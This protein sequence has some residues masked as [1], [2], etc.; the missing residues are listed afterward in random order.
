MSRVEIVKDGKWALYCFLIDAADRPGH[1]GSAADAWA[2]AR[3]VVV[4]HPNKFRIVK[5]E[6]VID[7]HTAGLEALGLKLKAQRKE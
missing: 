3:L 2:W 4:R 6:P 7:C 5:D 1:F